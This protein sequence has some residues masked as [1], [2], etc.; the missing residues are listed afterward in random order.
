MKRIYKVLW[1]SGAAVFWWGALV[2]LSWILIGTLIPDSCSRDEVEEFYSQNGEYRA[3]VLMT[4]CGSLASPQTQIYVERVT[5]KGFP[6]FN[7]YET[8]SLIRLDGR[9]DQV[10]YAVIWQSDNELLITGFEFHKMMA[11]KNQSWGPY[12]PRV[13]FEPNNN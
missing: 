5:K 6:I 2:I 8:D 4:G 13:Y 10:N 9:P 11:F 1:H 7:S 3:Y 12:L